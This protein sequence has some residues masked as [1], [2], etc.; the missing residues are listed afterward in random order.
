MAGTLVFVHGTGVRDPGFHRSMA[1]IDK[2]LGIS[3]VTIRGVSW[4]AMHGVT[5]ERIPDALPPATK[6]LDH[7]PGQS[8][9]IAASASARPSSTYQVKRRQLS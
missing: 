3:G 1:L 9:V 2:H 7:E 4:G 6:G 8:E 5:T